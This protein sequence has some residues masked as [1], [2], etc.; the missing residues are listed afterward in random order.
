MTKFSLYFQAAMEAQEMERQ[1]SI[2]S[3][4]VTPHIDGH[5]RS[6][7]KSL[8]HRRQESTASNSSVGKGWKPEGETDHAS[9]IS[10]PM[11]QQMEII[12]GYIRQAKQA[13]RLDEVT[14]LEQNLQDLQLE[15][16]KQRQ[17]SM[18]S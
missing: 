18:Q 6:D 4:A 10:D 16:S 12:R 14:M 11:L 3:G 8:G 5:S 13:H 2:Q 1:K 17:E 9:F 7:S 15:F